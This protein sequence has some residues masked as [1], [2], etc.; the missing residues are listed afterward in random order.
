MPHSRDLKGW[1]RSCGDRNKCAKPMETRLSP[2]KLS[3][4]G[5]FSTSML[6]CRGECS[7]LILSISML[8][9]YRGRLRKLREM[10]KKHWHQGC[11]WNVFP[12]QCKAEASSVSGNCHWLETTPLTP[13]RTNREPKNLCKF[14]MRTHLFN[15]NLQGL[16]QILELSICN[17][18]IITGI[19]YY[20]NYGWL[21]TLAVNQLTRDFRWHETWPFNAQVT[22]AIITRPVYSPQ[23]QMTSCFPWGKLIEMWKT[24]GFPRKMIYKL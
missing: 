2:G 10:P 19:S 24:Y 22:Y 20:I 23:F 3:T 7:F 9:N 6:A 4:N 18:I 17:Y 21:Y 1:N 5:G 11:N 8:A 13:L 14:S 15:E 16:W 12:D